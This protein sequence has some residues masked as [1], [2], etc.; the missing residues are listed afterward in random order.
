MA[1]YILIFLLFSYFALTGGL[2]DNAA[3]DEYK[4]RIIMVWKLFVT[5][6]LLQTIEEFLYLGK[7]YVLQEEDDLHRQHF[8]RYILHIYNYNL[9][10][11]MTYMHLCIVCS[12]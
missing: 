8:L 11:S 9:F 10:R 5:N 1:I 3:W 4:T 12:S 6:K 7:F 2:G